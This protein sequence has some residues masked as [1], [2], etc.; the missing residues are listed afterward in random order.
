MV[1]IT[2][3]AEEET[4]IGEE[5]PITYKSWMKISDTSPTYHRQ[6]ILTKELLKTWEERFNRTGSVSCKKADN[7]YQWGNFMYY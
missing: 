4:K 7:H 5:R 3:K 2:V 1:E 6:P